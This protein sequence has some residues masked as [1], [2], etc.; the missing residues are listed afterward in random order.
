M[1]SEKKQ[2]SLLKSKNYEIKGN[3][4]RAFY[5]AQNKLVFVLDSTVDKIKPNVLLIMSARGD[6]KWDDVLVNDYNVDLET[7]RPKKDN[8]YQK[9]DIEYDGLV[10]YDNLI[11]AYDDGD[12]I[13]RALR[14]LHDFR[15][16]SAHRSATERLAAA[17]SVADNARETIERT[18]DAIVELQAK[19]KA[20]RAKITNLRRGIGREPTKQ[21]AA[22]I[23]RAEAQL[24]ALTGKLERA[25]KRLENANKRLLVAE[26]DIAAAQAVLDLLSNVD[27]KKFKTVESATPVKKKKMSVEPEEDLPEETDEDTDAEFED[28]EDVVDDDLDDEDFDDDVENIDDTDEEVKPL[29]DKDPNIVDEKIAF[30]PISFDD[31]AVKVDNDA[32][33]NLSVTYDDETDDSNDVV[34]EP[35][36]DEKET[37]IADNNSAEKNN[38]SLEPP[39]PVVDKV[40]MPAEIDNSG[41]DE[42]QLD[43]IFE[44][45]EE[46]DD[47]DLEQQDASPLNVTPVPEQTNNEIVAA[48]TN[49]IV[50]SGENVAPINVTPVVETPVGDSAS[51]V[52]P[53]AKPVTENLVRPASPVAETTPVVNAPVVDESKHKPN[54]LYY[55][56]LLVLIALSVFT[57]WLY[58]RSNV[59]P[60]VMP[61]LTP[62]ENVVKQTEEVV[63][64]PT[65]N[66]VETVSVA[67]DVQSDDAD[68]DPF[69]ASGDAV[70]TEKTSRI[71]EIAENSLN[72][73]AEAAEIPVENTNDEP[74]ATDDETD[75]EPEAAPVVV[76]KP[77]Y[78]VTT[79][80]VFTS[81]EPA[82]SGGSLCDGDVAPD[83]NGCC[84]GETYSV[85]NNQNVCCPDSGGDC[86]PPLF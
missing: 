68:S 63:D 62:D 65:T 57:L 85:V 70:N 80:K 35:A 29:F 66:V 50:D 32:Q 64:V 8:K 23:L 56:L 41:D 2:K 37:E 55:V 84:P 74:V 44:D 72:K 59:S 76:N 13:N 54:L 6:R 25:K 12:N 17:T 4:L 73:I 27:D 34:V 77:E 86:F 7:V 24:D 15:E 47:D 46:D 22:K 42:A 30:K 31:M 18:G 19:I 20:V 21:S 52:A 14:D 28:V 53:V 69:V 11:R 71:E 49:E 83:T 3:S 39:K 33:Q 43:E 51:I 67:D 75:T 58:Q 82:V 16:M 10:V 78:K 1:P 48:P 26:D 81:D 45:L 38:I 9:L 36:Q 79:D 40:D 61:A 5:D 60:D